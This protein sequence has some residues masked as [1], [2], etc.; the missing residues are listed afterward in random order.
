M[1]ITQ[2]IQGFAV[3]NFLYRDSVNKM[4]IPLNLS[5]VVVVVVKGGIM[6]ISNVSTILY[7]H[8]RYGNRDDN[9]N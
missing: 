9:G 1:T 6:D 2:I 8:Y 4:K 7:L 5:M 3:D